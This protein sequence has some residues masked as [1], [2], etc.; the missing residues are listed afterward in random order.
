MTAQINCNKG[1]VASRRA[2]FNKLPYKMRKMRFMQYLV[3][4]RN[5]VWV[6]QKRDLQND[7]L[8]IEQGNNII[9]DLETGLAGDENRQGK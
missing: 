5:K 7:K 6:I 2:I 4:W 3:Y 9:L 1:K 8:D